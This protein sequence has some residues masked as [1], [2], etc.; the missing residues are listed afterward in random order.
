LISPER[1]ITEDA[2]D[3]VRIV[4][5]LLRRGDHGEVFR[6]RRTTVAWSASEAGLLQPAHSEERGTAARIR[7]GREALLIARDGDGPEA[8]RDV[9][10][11]AARR[12]GGSPFFKARPK[13]AAPA[14]PREAGEEERT[15]AL[16]AAIARAFPDP[17]GLSLSLSIARVRVTRAVVTSRALVL[18]GSAS[19]LVATGLVR[20]ADGT[21]P[22]AFQSAATFGNAVDALSRALAEAARPVAAAPPPAGTTDVVLSPAAASVFWHEVVGHPLEAEG[23]EHRS[24]LARVPNAVVGPPGLFVTADPTRRD[25]PGS[26]DCDDEGTP[27]RPVPLLEEGRVTGLLTDRRTAGGSSN[28]HGRCSDY[29]RPPRPRLSNLVVPA[30]GLPLAAL[31]ERCGSGLYV[32]EISSGSTDPESG[33]FLLVV[34]AADLVRRGKPA[35][36]VSRFALSGDLLSAL[37]HL[38]AERGDA[39]LPASGL[40]LC[41]KG[42]DPVPVGGASPAIVLRALAVAGGGS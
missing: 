30:G 18:C 16:A 32:R 6:E 27:A 17:R 21:R 10:R 1:E 3:A 20:R 15:A 31:L 35:A 2:D 39:S 41:L 12:A 24:V 22:F 4:S 33:R 36:P 40:G 14:P 42:G 28:G 11:D 25:L 38:E 37:R 26:F 5:G 8:L 29:R 23:G 13:A 7:R 19:R 9:V 34:E